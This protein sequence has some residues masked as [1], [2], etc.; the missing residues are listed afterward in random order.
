MEDNYSV[1]TNNRFAFFMD[2]EDDP[3]DMILQESRLTEKSPKKL[4]VSPT[5][6]KSEKPIKG[7]DQK[8]VNQQGKKPQGD[9]GG[10]KRKEVQCEDLSFGFI[11]IRKN[12]MFYHR[13]MGSR[14]P[15]V[16]RMFCS[17]LW[18]TWCV[19]VSSL[20]TAPCTCT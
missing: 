18:L 14:V 20:D 3:G 7:K 11:C 6:K 10:G 15:C 5:Q 17:V 8:V 1:A 4:A 13:S 2:E 19:L 9:N 12:R 16:R